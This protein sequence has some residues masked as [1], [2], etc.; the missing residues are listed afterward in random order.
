MISD[1]LEEFADL[2]V[3]VSACPFSRVEEDCPFKNYWDEKDLER[4]IKAL[5]LLPEKELEKLR[6]H[7]NVCV[8]QKL[9]RGE[10]MDQL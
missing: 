10:V 5:D 7:H 9:D 1:K 3:P 6:N 2:V 8:R 4:R